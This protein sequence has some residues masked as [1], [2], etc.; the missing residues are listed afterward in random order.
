M[1]DS[2]WKIEKKTL[3]NGE[4]VDFLV[5]TDRSQVTKDEIKDIIRLSEPWGK[6]SKG[7]FQ[8]QKR[9]NATP[10]LQ[11]QWKNFDTY[12]ENSVLES[13]GK[14]L[15][16]SW[17]DVAVNP[18]S[19]RTSDGGTTVS[20][21]TKAKGAKFEIPKVGAYFETQAGVNP[22]G[23]PNYQ[24][25]KAAENFF[26]SALSDLEGG[27]TQ[28][29]YVNGKKEVTQVPSIV[30]RAYNSFGIDKN[31]TKGISFSN[32]V[33]EGSNEKT[34]G[35]TF[36]NKQGVTRTA[37]LS[38]ILRYRDEFPE[39]LAK[40]FDG[41][42]IQMNKQYADIEALRHQANQIKEFK[43]LVGESIYKDRWN[44][45]SR[46]GFRE[47]LS[48]DQKKNLDNNSLVTQ[49][50]TLQRVIAEKLPLTKESLLKYTNLPQFGLS[51]ANKTETVKNFK[52]LGASMGIPE[53]MWYS[54][55]GINQDDA[56]DNFVT[57]VNQSRKGL[58]GIN[59][60]VGE[61]FVRNIEDPIAMD[62][63]IKKGDNATKAFLTKWEER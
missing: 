55:D 47:V 26:T 24:Q 52:I 60:T 50:K 6:N 25:A 39:E 58:T 14:N 31:N 40:N 54:S 12:Y 17:E 41:A 36:K 1:Q 35:I 62:M 22:V 57:V 2:G 63:A 10:E 44:S 61:D 51:V 30:D 19:N 32:I 8:L 43:S 13:I 46:N 15:G 21:E 27:Y 4:T 9:F 34:L 59:L 20:E 45:I 48:S 49:A 53:E 18:L 56:I 3:S 38:N 23:Y 28:V 7:Y 37:T 33:L 11:D 5:K 29:T 16:Y 42:F